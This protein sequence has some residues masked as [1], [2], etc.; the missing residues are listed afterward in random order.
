MHFFSLSLSP[1][2]SL[3]SVSPYWLSSFGGGGHGHGDD[4]HGGRM[5]LSSECSWS[6]AR[7]PLWGWLP[8]CCCCTIK[9]FLTYLGGL[10]SIEFA[11]P[12]FALHFAPSFGFF[13]FPQKKKDHTSSSTFI[14]LSDPVH[15]NPSSSP[16]TNNDRVNRGWRIHTEPCLRPTLPSHPPL[17]APLGAP[18]PRRSTLSRALSGQTRTETRQMNH[19]CS[20]MDRITTRIL[21]MAPRLDPVLASGAV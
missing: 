1:L 10:G 11:L 16:A 9:P 13:F 5:L 8:R 18:R 6:C 7:V 21:V 2:S 12:P 14:S 4:R 15:W 19:R 17:P 20:T 3:L